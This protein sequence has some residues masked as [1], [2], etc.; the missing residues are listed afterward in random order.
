MDNSLYM[1]FDAKSQNEAFARSAVASFVIPLNPSLEE[2]N[3]IKTAVSEAATNAVVHA[4]KDE[5]GTIEIFETITGNTVEIIIQDQGVGIEDIKTAIKPFY[6]TKPDEERAGMGF[7]VMQALMD[8]VEVKNREGG[9]LIVKLT[10]H[11]N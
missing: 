11:I 10:K 6:T 3:D 7:A 2:I 9:G 8:E 5:L 1:K 4:Y